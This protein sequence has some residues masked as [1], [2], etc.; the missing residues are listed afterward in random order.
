M[1]FIFYLFSI[2]SFSCNLKN[3]VNSNFH[4]LDDSSIIKD[5]DPALKFGIALHGF[6]LK[7]SLIVKIK[8]NFN[9][10]STANAMKFEAVHPHAD[11]YH[12]NE[13]DSLVEFAQE[14]NMVVR[15]HTLLWS[16][17]NPYWLFW[18]KK[19]NLV[20]RSL[21]DQRLKEHIHTVVSRYKGKVYAWDVV[22]EAIY[23]NDKEFLKTNNWYKIMGADYIKKAFQ[24][25]HEADSTAVLFYN[26][27]DAERPDK[28]KRITKLIKWLQS[29]KVPI[30]GIGIQAHWKL[31]SPSLMDI[32]NA[33]NTY[34]AL[35]LQVQITE[36]DVVMTP[37]FKGSE[38]EKMNLLASRYAEI[39]EV[40]HKN[41]NKL[42][43]IT[44]WQTEDIPAKYP[45]LF[46]ADFNPTKIYQA[47]LNA[48]SAN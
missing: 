18:D 19:G 25:A 4:E 40:F 39:F 8:N 20:H 1:K 2:I 10:L 42:S 38:E 36:L 47:V 14:H 46:D 22:N 33:I 11:E 13:A 32:E 30:H 48:W 21:L 17:R 7:D 29:E 6:N 27:Y 24:Y 35:G 3:E 12:W 16:N 15:G 44:F 23:D 34:A 5:T 28:L 9:S 45:P 31:D 26:D 41:R 43:G 37:D